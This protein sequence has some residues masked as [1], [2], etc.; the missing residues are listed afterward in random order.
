MSLAAFTAGRSR[1]R[2]FFG[3]AGRRSRSGPKKTRTWGL[4]PTV[5]GGEMDTP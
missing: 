2:L 1:L 3:G 4:G 5:G